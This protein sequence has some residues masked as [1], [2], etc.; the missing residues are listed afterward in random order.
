MQTLVLFV[1]CSPASNDTLRNDNS[2]AALTE[3][4]FQLVTN[5]QPGKENLEN[6][7]DI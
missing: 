2:G 1:L 6:I 5:R 7:L 4:I 3:M